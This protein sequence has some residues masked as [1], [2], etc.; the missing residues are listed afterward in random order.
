[1]VV[2]N[3]ISNLTKTKAKKVLFITFDKENKTVLKE[4]KKYDD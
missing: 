2:D 4:I 3:E 1:M